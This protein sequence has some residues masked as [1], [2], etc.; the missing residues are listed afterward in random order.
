MNIKEILAKVAKG[1]SLADEEKSFL[2]GYDPQA[3]ID[4]ASAAARRKAEKE[5]SDAKSAL[6]KLQSDFDDYKTSHNSDKKQTELDKALARIAKLEKA[7]ADKDAALAATARAA[8]VRKLAKEAGIVPANGIAAET[9]DLLVDNLLAKVDLEDADAV[10]TAFDG[11]RAANGAMIA[12]LGKGGVGVK[13]LP[14]G[15]Y[16]SRNPFAKDS[17][18][19]TEALKLRVENPTLAASLEAAAEK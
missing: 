3:D 15:N 1:E 17:Y 11:F 6:E 10:K 16:S 4:K 18:N 12:D 5:A 8:T 13:G 7:N 2:G 14:S 9:L 19:L